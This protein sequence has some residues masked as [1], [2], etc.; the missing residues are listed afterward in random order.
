MTTTEQL[1]LMFPDGYDSGNILKRLPDRQRRREERLIGGSYRR[2]FLKAVKPYLTEHAT[3]MELGPGRGSWTRALLESVPRGQV[4]T[5]DFLDV[6][7]WLNPSTYGGRLVCHEI[8]DNSFAAVPARTFDF[9]FSFGVLCH[10]TGDAIREIMANAVPK[11]QPGAVAVHQY[12][13][14]KKLERLGWHDDRHGVLAATRELP[15]DDEWNF[16]PRNDP[17]KMAAICE[18][19]GWIV[20][21][22]D[23]GL[24]RRDSVIRLR[25]PDADRE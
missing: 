13:D 16:W 1:K 24:F 2:L 15:D 3:V 20:E 9:F 18:E 23:V 4:H 22:P 17:E 10:Q 8:A 6:T 14:W 12:G 19:A 25:A 11:M 5:L 7:E 21:E